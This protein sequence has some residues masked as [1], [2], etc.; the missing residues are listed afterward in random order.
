MRE[1]YQVEVEVAYKY[2]VVVEKGQNPKEIAALCLDEAVNDSGR[3]EPTEFYNRKIDIAELK[4]FKGYEPVYSHDSTFEGMDI[5]DY[6]REYEEEQEELA[7]NGP[8]I[9]P[10]KGQMELF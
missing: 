3:P 8:K 4:K 7:E 10:A 5:E 6:I 9:E 1:L 2:F